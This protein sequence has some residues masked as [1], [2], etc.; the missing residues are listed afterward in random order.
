MST[1][2]ATIAAPVTVDTALIL[3]RVFG[4][5]AEF[6]LNVQRRNDLWDALH[7][8]EAARAHRARTPS[9][10]KRGM[11]SARHGFL[12]YLR[13][14]SGYDEPEILPSSIHPISL[15]SADGRHAGIGDRT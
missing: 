11:N 10:P 9:A 7:F 1:S 14:L 6:W 4:N 13:S 3:A 15:M 5:S 2:C 8:T 12:S